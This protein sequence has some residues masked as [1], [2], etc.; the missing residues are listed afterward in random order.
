MATATMAGAR[1][2][3]ERIYHVS[4]V[5]LIWALVL[6]GFSQSFF[7]RPLFPKVV[8]TPEPVFYVHGALFVG[9]LALLGIQTMLIAT[10]ETR[11]HRRLGLVGFA[12][13]PL[14]LAMGL[15][16]ATFGANRP[17]GFTDIPGTTTSHFFGVLVV[18]ML[19]FTGFA[20]L[21]LVLRKRPQAHKRLMLLAAIVL[22]EAGVTRTQ[23]LTLTTYNENLAFLATATLLIPM[24][25]WDLA[26]L[27]RLHP[28][29]LWGGLAFLAYGPLREVFADTPAWRSVG[30]WAVHLI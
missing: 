20:G 27:R 12:I 1:L 14:M 28:A 24:V 26:T 15:Y 25:A 7:L 19:V 6:W 21:G 18:W 29:T 2:P 13:V 23:P 16:V 3:A 10:G 4:M 22:A 30:S 17:S 8:T 11:A 9:W 5:A